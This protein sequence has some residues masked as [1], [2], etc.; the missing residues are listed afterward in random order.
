M[1]AEATGAGESSKRKLNLVALLAG[2]AE[3]IF[4]LLIDRKWREEGSSGLEDKPPLGAAFRVGVL[5]LGIAEPLAFMQ[6]RR[7]CRARRAALTL[8]SAISALV[9]GFILRAVFVLGGRESARAG[10][11]VFP[12]YGGSVGR[13]AGRYLTS[14]RG[15]TRHPDGATMES[16]C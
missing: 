13:R 1:A 6:R 8:L 14:V 15:L 4:A 5:G 2:A 12:V 9:G 16:Q 7:C 11:G 10:G 3:L